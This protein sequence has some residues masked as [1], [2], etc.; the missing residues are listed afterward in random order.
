MHAIYM[1]RCFMHNLSSEINL[2]L[3]VNM[4]YCY[5]IFVFAL[6]CCQ[7]MSKGRVKEFD[8]PYNL[9]QNSDSLFT[10]MVEKTGTSAS[11]KLRQMAA[12]SHLSR[13]ALVKTKQ[14]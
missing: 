5:I 6:N 3:V 8:S 14:S 7:V 9:L 12:D 2:P 13:T 10:K 11:K 4:L 1:G